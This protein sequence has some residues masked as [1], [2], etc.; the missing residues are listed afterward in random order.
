MKYFFSAC[1]YYLLLYPL[2]LLPLGLLYGVADGLGWFFFNIVGYR[3]KV[4]VQ[5]IR[6]SFPEKSEAEIQQIGKAFY[7]HLCTMMV[8][9]VKSFSM[10]KNELAKRLTY[11]GI[12]EIERFAQQGRSV[13]L[14]AGH[15]HNYEWLVTGLDPVF[16]H[17][18]VALYK[19]LNNPFFEKKVKQSRA[20]LGLKLESIYEIKE[21]FAD[22]LKKEPIAVVFAMDQSP[23]N[24]QSAYWME[25]LKQDT[26]VLYGTEK[27]AREFDLPIFYAHLDKDKK[28]YYSARF[29]LLTDTPNATHYG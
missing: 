24:P 10:S 18:V 20:Q 26:A 25:F 23:S 27:Y 14:T 12:E 5:N 28:G 4:V 17:Q 7:D 6:Q 3:K 21:R 22:Q 1:F 15:R 13:I 16:K 2:S 11:N 29:E 19:P 8:E 9:S